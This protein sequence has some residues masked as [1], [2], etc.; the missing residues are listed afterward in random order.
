MQNQVTGLISS[1]KAPPQKC[2]VGRQRQAIVPALI[3]PSRTEMRPLF[4]TAAVALATVTLVVPARP[5]PLLAFNASSSAPIGFYRITTGQYHVGDLVLVRLPASASRLAEQRGYLPA[6]VPA[7]KRIAAAEDDSVCLMGVLVIING[8]VAAVRLARD[9]NARNMP[10][11]SGCRTLQHRQ[12]FLLNGQGHS[13]DGRYFGI[14]SE[15]DVIG[16]A[17]RWP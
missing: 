6:G 7:L 2:A 11:W 9:A 12:I 17:A 8:R 13:F 5:R 14:T 1:A 4:Y 16:R 10:S 15:R 3:C